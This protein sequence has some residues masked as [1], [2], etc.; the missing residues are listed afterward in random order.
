MTIKIQQPDVFDDILKMFGK[1]RAVY[2]GESPRVWV[3]SS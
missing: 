1:K 3:L 2:A